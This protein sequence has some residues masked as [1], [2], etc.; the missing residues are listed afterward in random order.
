MDFEI[1]DNGEFPQ[2]SLNDDKQQR[3]TLI[4]EIQFSEGFSLIFV[5]CNRFVLRQNQVASIRISHPELRIQEINLGKPVPHLLYAL[6][7]SLESPPP[8]AVF[9]Y[10]MENW[11]SGDKDPRSIE[12]IV[13]LNAGRNHFAID[14]PCPLVLWMPEYL[15]SM[16]Q[17]GAP[18]FASIRSGYYVFASP[19]DDVT[20]TT[21][22]TPGY[23]TAITLTPDERKERLL[24]LERLLQSLQSLP[25]NAQDIPAEVRTLNRLITT[26]LVDNHFDKA[27]VYAQRAIEFSEQF[28][29]H[30]VLLKAESYKNFA[31]VC[32]KIEQF[33]QAIEY[34][35]KAIDLYNQVKQQEENLGVLYGSLA[36]IS[37]QQN[38][39][40]EA[41]KQIEWSH[42]YLRK[43]EPYSPVSYAN[44]PIRPCT[45]ITLTK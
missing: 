1:D 39:Y 33:D 24:E 40:Q 20:L 45:D 14:C 8:N 21:L 41:K 12:F 10:G 5:V 2:Y 15:H 36:R 25:E 23:E 19:P 4:R 7:Q 34:F 11:I 27:L 16:I 29:G 38:Q 26:H 42:H 35:S 13:N 18:D 3:E 9:V 43:A 22:L 37:L 32:R 44:T 31:E 17:R 28:V 30:N 6:R